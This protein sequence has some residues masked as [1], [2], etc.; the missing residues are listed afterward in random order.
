[1]KII[2]AVHS[3][4]NAP[5]NVHAV[6]LPLIGKII[7]H[8]KNLISLPILS[9]GN[10]FGVSIVEEMIVCSVERK[11][12]VGVIAVPFEHASKS[13]VGV[14]VGKRCYLCILVGQ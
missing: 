13:G 12:Q 11:E 1:M 14:D 7:L 10:L 5:K 6:W 4:V 8:F 3:F 2:V 9:V